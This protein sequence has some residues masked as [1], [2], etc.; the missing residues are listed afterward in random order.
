MTFTHL[1]P[2]DPLRVFGEQ[3]SCCLL[4]ES[5]MSMGPAVLHTRMLR[6]SVGTPEQRMRF[7][8]EV[9]GMWWDSLQSP[10]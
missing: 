7:V 3:M 9:L 2:Y 6:G 8:Q 5:L 1:D 10:L 4:F